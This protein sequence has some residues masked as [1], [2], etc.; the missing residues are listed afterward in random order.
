MEFCK[1]VVSLCERRFNSQVQG[2]IL[3]SLQLYDQ[4]DVTKK[5]E[6]AES[7]FNICQRKDRGE[8]VQG[9]LVCR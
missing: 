5:M 6:E 7:H 4:V 3:C 8:V 1:F 9:K 2:H